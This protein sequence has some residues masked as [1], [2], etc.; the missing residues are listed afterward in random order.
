MDR[1]T[2]IGFIQ[3]S[4]PFSRDSLNPPRCFQDNLKKI[5]YKLKESVQGVFGIYFNLYNSIVYFLKRNPE[6]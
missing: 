5:I 1:K 3:S 6:H 2:V 4:P